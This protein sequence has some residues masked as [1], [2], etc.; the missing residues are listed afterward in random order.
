MQAAIKNSNN[1][2]G[3]LTLGI[4]SIII[5]FIGLILGMLGIIVYRKTNNNRNALTI[6]GLICSIIGIIIQL[7]RTL[8]LITYYFFTSA[9]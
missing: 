3:A 5:P 4:L 2:V 6:S 7:L 9:G 1:G 8:S